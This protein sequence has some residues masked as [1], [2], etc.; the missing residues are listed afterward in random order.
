MAIS[1]ATQDAVRALWVL[2]SDHGRTPSPT[3]EAD[4]WQDADPFEEPQDTAMV[5]FPGIP[6][7]EVRLSGDLDDTVTLQGAIVF[8]V[9]RRDTVAFVA[10]VIA[11]DAYLRL[12]GSHLPDFLRGVLGFMVGKLLVVPVSGASYE[13]SWPYQMIE[14]ESLWVPPTR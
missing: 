5:E 8:D 9:P 3:P 10:A 13:Q 6:T 7:I 1:A 11:G 14:V 2:G 4:T 12:L